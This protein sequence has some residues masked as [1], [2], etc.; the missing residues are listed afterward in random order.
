MWNLL[1]LVLWHS[2]IILNINKKTLKAFWYLKS[3]TRFAR[4]TCESRWEDCIQKARKCCVLTAVQLTEG[5]TGTSVIKMYKIPAI[6][7]TL[8]SKSLHKGGRVTHL[9]ICKTHIT[10]AGKMTMERGIGTKK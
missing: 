8:I 2:P 10:S 5:K 7:P 3:G 9:K 6:N 4:I 1:L